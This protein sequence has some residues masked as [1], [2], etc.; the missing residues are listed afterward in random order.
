MHSRRM[1]GGRRY[2]SETQGR[3]EN[4]HNRNQPRQSQAWYRPDTACQPV[5]H[6]ASVWRRKE[7][8]AGERSKPF[9]PTARCGRV[10]HAIRVLS[11]GAASSQEQCDPKAP[12]KRIQRA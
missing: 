11:G 10:G 9:G 12:R 3:R 2:F 7:G 6:A 4:L 1:V 5:T 8:A